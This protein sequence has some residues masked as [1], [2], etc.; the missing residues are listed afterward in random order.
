MG[1]VYS[2]ETDG[3]TF[4]EPVTVKIALDSY[5]YSVGPHRVE[6]TAGDLVSQRYLMTYSV[7]DI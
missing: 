6:I 7:Y 5:L 2:L 3:L 1:L 4:Q